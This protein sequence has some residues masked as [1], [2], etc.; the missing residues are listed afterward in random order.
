M[1]RFTYVL[2]ALTL[3]VSL[4]G[5]QQNPPKP[6]PAA[7]E[8][9]RTNPEAVVKAY[10]AACERR[11]IDTG[12]A[13]LNL[14]PKLQTSFHQIAEELMRE[15][16]GTNLPDLITEFSFLPGG[17]RAVPS[18]TQVQTGKDQATV[19]LTEDKPRQ[20]TFVVT[21]T[22]DG[23]WAVDLRASIL[24]TTGQKSSF[25]FDQIMQEVQQRGG[26]Q[27]QA[28]RWVS[29]ERLGALT[30]NLREYIAEHGNKVPA[31]ATWMDDL[32]RYCLDG[33]FLHR[34]GLA[35]DQYGYALNV[36]LAG[37]TLPKTGEEQS[38]L[39]LVYETND[40]VRNAAGDPAEELPTT[41]TP[42]APPYVALGTGEVIALP[43]GTTLEQYLED[44]K[45][46]QQCRS[47]LR[48]LGK[49]FR[50]YARDHD[51]MLPPAASWCD[52]IS[53][54]VP[55][56]QLKPELFRCP[57]LPMFDYGYAMNSE[58]AGTD[59]RIQQDQSKQTLLLHAK[60]G[61]RN[62]ALRLP[63]KV[64]GAPHTSAYVEAGG[65]RVEPV[66]LLDGMT[67]DVREGRPYPSG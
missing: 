28:D 8:V 45:Q 46:Q 63:P 52:D 16:P 54:Y 61:V 10:V 29:Q 50:A 51:G 39:I 25:L 40:P 41:G 3:S 23:K 5:A 34:P 38:R 24:K 55:P 49:A 20:R 62:E 65:T 56:E 57:C 2:L 9:D 30:N 22:P 43:P 31:A 33:S 6:P 13:L 36:K 66:L 47:N 59:I 44:D 26:G 64:E 7:P 11:D 48:T 4:C 19:T 27:P 58:L 21:K 42:E 67:T 35:K 14:D 15:P 1:S 37:T 53:P 17:V 60:A 18:S 32:E 12:V